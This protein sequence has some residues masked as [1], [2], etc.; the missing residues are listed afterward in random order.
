MVRINTDVLIVGGGVSGAVA[1]ITGKS[2]YL[3]KKFVVV[4]KESQAIDACSIPYVFGPEG[5]AGQILVSDR[6]LSRMGV[7][8]ETDEIVSVDQA[9]HMCQTA[10]GSDI[11]FEKLILALGSVPKTP[12]W[13]Q[14][15][16]MENVFNIPKDYT[17][18]Q[19]MVTAL[20]ACRK[21]VIVGGGFVGFEIAYELARAN[22][23]VTIVEAQP[24]LLGIAFDSEIGHKA[25]AILE[26]CGIE[27]KTGIEATGIVGETRAT[28]VVLSS[29]E[30]LSAD[31]VILATGYHP[32]TSLAEQ[33]GLPIGETGAI[34]VDQYMR[35]AN[36]NILAAGDCAETRCFITGRPNRIM[37]ASTACSEARTAAINLY[38]LSAVMTFTGT[39]PIFCTAVGDTAFGAAGL[40]EKRARDMKFSIYTSTYA[41]VDKHPESL[42]GT[43]EQIVKLIIARNSGVIIGGEI[44]GGA[45]TGELTNLIAFAIQ[46]RMTVNSILVGQIGTHSLLTAHPVAYPLSI[47]AQI[48]AQRLWN[49]SSA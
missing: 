9:R 5:Q 25:Q 15:K 41:G 21:I 10:G 16:S 23:E 38:Q 17:Y 27:V 6:T 18:I 34:P 45:S 44:V 35:T 46:N 33:A 24:H 4:R 47:A 30:T 3:T 13:L 43:H 22:R 19:R 20:G 37:L 12:E 42:P 7:S 29:G 48:I 32:Q 28:G 1:A 31:A 40:T 26:Q 2:F 14:S 11:S 8:I 36:P 49:I 39:V